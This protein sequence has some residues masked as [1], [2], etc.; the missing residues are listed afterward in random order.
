LIVW[1]VADLPKFLNEDGAA[2]PKGG[3]CNGKPT[4]WWFPEF[5]RTITLKQKHEILKIAAQA[6]MICRE[7]SVSA[8][9]LE[10]SLPHEPFG[11]WGGFDEQQ[12]LTLR[13][14]KG[15]RPAYRTHA[16]LRPTRTKRMPYVQTHG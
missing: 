7:C 14:S 1:L 3:A 11:I 6:T 9:C 13:R 8:E 2:P 12:R 16:G 5:H 10:Y 15:I 4:E